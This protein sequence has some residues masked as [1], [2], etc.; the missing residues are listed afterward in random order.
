VHHIFIPLVGDVPGIPDEMRDLMPLGKT[1]RAMVL[2]GAATDA[3]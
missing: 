2:W 3:H 1:G